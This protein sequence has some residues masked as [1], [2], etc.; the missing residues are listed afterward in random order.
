MGCFV[1]YII[2]W[3]AFGEAEVA[4]TL[5]SLEGA[6]Q[7]PLATA[8]PA[9]VEEG[10]ERCERPQADAP[11]GHQVRIVGA[12]AVQRGQR[13]LQKG[14]C[15]RRTH[16]DSGVE[17]LGGNTRAALGH[18]VEVR[19]EPVEPAIDR[20]GFFTRQCAHSAAVAVRARHSL[21]DAE[22]GR[23]ALVGRIVHITALTLDQ[24]V[25]QSVH[26]DCIIHPN[27]PPR[28]ADV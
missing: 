28:V 18:F 20:R 27:S 14:R 12:V 1:K 13:A 19:P 11:V 17:Q 25:N 24:R 3:A 10:V 6:Q 8:L 26:I 22:A 15:D 9:N 23:P 21:A 7:D 16:V 2:A 5:Q 4:L